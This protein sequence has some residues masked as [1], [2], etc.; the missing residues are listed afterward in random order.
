[1]AKVPAEIP[2]EG[3]SLLSQSLT[4]AFIPRILA[5]NKGIK[6]DRA[7]VEKYTDVYFGE[8]PFASFSLGHYCEAYIDWGPLGMMVHLFIYG[9]IGGIL[10]KV[11][12]RRGQSINPI[13]SFG[14]LWV[15]LYPW[16][17]FQQDMVVVAGKTAWGALCQLILFFP[18]YTLI[19]RFITIS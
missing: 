9:V 16:G 5:P 3:G 19:N 4:F 13:L 10:F 11:T 15:I 2:H 14:L 18:I 1:M 8:N 6:N 17:T 7:K 12:M